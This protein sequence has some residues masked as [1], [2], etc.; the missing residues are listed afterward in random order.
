MAG[1]SEDLE[2]PIWADQMLANDIAG[3]DIFRSAMHKGYMV[4][5]TGPLFNVNGE[6][7]GVI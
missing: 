3:A 7:V 5:M 6:A 1:Y 2:P 4:C